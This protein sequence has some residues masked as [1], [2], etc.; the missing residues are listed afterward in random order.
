[1]NKLEK[2]K[3]SKWIKGKI[4]QIKLKDGSF[5]YCQLT[6]PPAINFFN[7]RTFKKDDYR[8]ENIINSSILF[9]IG[10]FISAINEESWNCV[11]RA[12]VKA[13]HDIE[14]WLFRYDS[15]AKKFYLH[16][17]STGEEILCTWE[18]CKGLEEAAVW[19]SEGVARRLLDQLEGR[20]SLR[21]SYLK[22]EFAKRFALCPDEKLSNR[23][24]YL[25]P[26]FL[27]YEGIEFD[28]PGPVKKDK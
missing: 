24:E 6:N 14:P 25:K 12:E 26:E 20:P 3:R 27:Q 16:K 15:L 2:R 22:P 18:E 11:G 5:G 9:R 23:E 10:V 28:P 4:F 7:Y 8:I 21:Y 17:G 19:A 1:M 13:E